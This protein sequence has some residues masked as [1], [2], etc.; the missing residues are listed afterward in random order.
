MKKFIILLLL[1]LLVEGDNVIVDGLYV[2]HRGKKAVDDLALKVDDYY[3][4]V[5]LADSVMVRLLSEPEPVDTI[6]HP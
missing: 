2:W 3:P 1:Y 4:K 6:I 5:Q